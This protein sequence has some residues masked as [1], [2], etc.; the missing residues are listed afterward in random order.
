MKKVFSGIALLI[1]GVL[2]LSFS[3]GSGKCSKYKDGKFSL[4]GRSTGL[5]YIIT[6]KGSTQTEIT[7]ETGSISKLSI[8]WLSDCSFEMKFISSTRKMDAET[9]KLYENMILTVQILGGTDR[10]YVCRSTSNID[11]SPSTDT[12]W[13][14]R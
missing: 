5:H 8:K 2:V 3:D 10:Y 12:M 7:V 11:S 14:K 4:F 13:I 9:R 6:R 1:S